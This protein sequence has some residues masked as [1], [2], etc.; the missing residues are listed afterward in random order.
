MGIPIRYSLNKKEEKTF[1]TKNIVPNKTT[2]S[3]GSKSKKLRKENKKLRKELS[4]LRRDFIDIQ[5]KVKK[6]KKSDKKRKRKE[7]KDKGPEKKKGKVFRDEPGLTS[8]QTPPPPPPK[9]GNKKNATNSNLKKVKVK[10]PFTNSNNKLMVSDA[11]YKNNRHVAQLVNKYRSLADPDEKAKYKKGLAQIFSDAML[12]GVTEFEK[13]CVPPE[14]LNDAI[15]LYEK[16]TGNKVTV[17]SET[18]SSS[19]S[20]ESE[21]EGPA[22]INTF[23]GKMEHYQIVFPKEDM[24][25]GF[26]ETL[27]GD[28][29]KK[30]EA[31]LMKSFKKHGAFKFYADLTVLMGRGT[32][33]AEDGTTS[34]TEEREVKLPSGGEKG[35]MLIVTKK[36]DVYTAPG[37]VFRALTDALSD[38]SDLGSGFVFLGCISLDIYVSKQ[39]YGSRVYNRGSTTREL[40]TNTGVEEA[41]NW[42]PLPKWLTNKYAIINPQPPSYKVDDNR[43]FEWCVLRAKHPWKGTIKTGESPRD[44][45][46]LMEFVGKEV[47]LPDG[48]DYPIPLSDS[49]LRKIEEVNDFSF[50]IFALGKAEGE[51]RPIYLSELK[52]DGKQ[53]IHLGVLSDGDIH[54]FVYIKN[55][56][57]I[58]ND[59]KWKTCQFYCERCLSTHKSK[60]ALNNHM[61]FCGKH[62]PCQMRLPEVGSKEQ[63]VTFD[64]WHQLQKIPFVIYADFECILTPNDKG[65]DNHIPSCFCYHIK[66][67]YPHLEIIPGYEGK[68]LGE[69]RIY[70]GKDC[71][72]KFFESLF[73]DTDILYNINKYT[74]NKYS[75]SKGDREKFQAETDCHICRKPLGKKRHFDHDH[76]TGLYRGASHPNCNLKY[77]TKKMEYIPCV[78]HNLKGYDG[79]NLLAYL[80]EKIDDISKLEVIAKNLEKFTCMTINHVRFIDSIQFINGSL[81]AQVNNLRSSLPEEERSRFFPEV[82]KLSLLA[83]GDLFNECMMKGVY[84]YEW[85]DSFEKMDVKKYP[86][87]EV[88]FSRLSND[89]VSDEDYARGLRMWKGFG[90][91]TM[92]DYTELYCKL[93]VLLLES[94]FEAFRR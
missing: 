94:L 93:D 23:Q 62:E 17:L 22:P 76:F 43:C 59:N 75:P 1:N 33:I 39:L 8:L 46:D 70:T 83:N 26:M 52:E 82:Y 38:Y 32:T 58:I 40:Q 49:I 44:C 68:P 86:K 37:Q 85:M 88:F 4:D 64:S 84:P 13:G 50:S 71:M 14:I 45:T 42:L 77:T 19:S 57:G 41:G 2:M 51:I 80:H 63:F 10:N 20:S 5:K 18:S 73:F 24:G 6:I 81:E 78:I 34:Y 11:S 61:A 79:Y 90:C 9:Q 89:G 36:A 91:K 92:K 15:D 35:G 31:I 53:H 47:K 87:K 54:H 48:I 72:N 16:R 25:K 55:L 12:L 30:F 7:K 60:E 74:E 65:G 69:P 56:S 67:S 21:S 3:D 27:A 28:T 66:C 29:T